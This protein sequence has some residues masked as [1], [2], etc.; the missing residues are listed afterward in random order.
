MISAYACGRDVSIPFYG[1]GSWI[2]NQSSGIMA[3]FLGYYH[4]VVAWSTP[5][6]SSSTRWDWTPDYFVDPC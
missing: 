1:Y 4:Q 2:N 6:Y 5:A 3:R